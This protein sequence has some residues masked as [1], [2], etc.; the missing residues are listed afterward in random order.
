[1]AQ[2]LPYL[3]SNKNVAK[4]FENILSAQKPS[5]FTHDYLQNTIGLKGT[6]DRALITLLRNL[7][8]LDA[9]N[10]PTS[11]YD[12]LKNKMAAKIAIAEGIRK[13]YAPLFKANENANELNA[14]QLKGLISQV[15]GAEAE[16]VERIANTF[17]ALMKLGDF[18]TTPASQEE[19]PLNDDGEEDDKADDAH[20]ENDKQ[21]PQKG[22]R[23]EFHYNIQIHLPANGTEDTYLNIFN[24]IRRTFR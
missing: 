5:T 23:P 13:A 6:N 3:A 21:K 14:D 11:Y 24:A 9:A 7:G 15:S 4:L 22:P 16:R 1:M 12:L 8:F 10:T 18:T 17:N 20:L 2:P 19:E